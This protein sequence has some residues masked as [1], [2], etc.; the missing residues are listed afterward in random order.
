MVAILLSSAANLSSNAT[1]STSAPLAALDSIRTS[2]LAEIE[3]AANEQNAEAWRVAYLGRSG[4]LT[5]MLRTVGTFPS[6]QR[7]IV[8]AA[9]NQIKAELEAALGSRI[10]AL[11]SRRVGTLGQDAIDVSL[12]G[13]AVR[14]GRFHPSTQ[15]MREICAIFSRMG[16]QAVEGP[17]AEWDRYNFEMLNIP[18]DHPARDM[19]DTFWVDANRD[20]DGGFTTLLRTHTSPMQ[21]RIME[22]HEPP[23]RVVVPGK[24]YRYEATDASHESQFHQIEGLAVDKGITLA[25]LKHTI[26]KFASQLFGEGRRVRFRCD[27]FPFVEPGVDVSV[28]CFKCDG[29]DLSCSICRGS[30]WLEIMGAGMVHPNVL[31]AVGYDPKVYSGFAFGMG[32]ERIAMLKY[33]IDDVR[34]FLAN[35]L[36]FLS[37]F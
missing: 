10:Q 33:G 15:I 3:E 4:K 9:A 31:K 19:F 37:Q 20:P 24:V 35:D 12:P 28:D 23:I 7:R 2:A 16:F 27:Y 29:S 11:Q 26:F 32:P 8:G 18:T 21:A 14:T 34:H 1:L 13:R 6:E 30:G 17:D 25:N 36:R 5:M 22:A